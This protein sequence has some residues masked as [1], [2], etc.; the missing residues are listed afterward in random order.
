MTGYNRTFLLLFL[1]IISLSY[2]ADSNWT[3]D[4]D[5]IK[6]NSYKSNLSEE[7]RDNY[8]FWIGLRNSFYF[9]DNLNQLEKLV[10]YFTPEEEKYYTKLYKFS[11]PCLI[12]GG[13]LLVI[14]FVYL[15][16]RFLLRGCR[17]PK[18]VEKS[19]H[20]SAYFF[21]IF[22]VVVG[23]VCMIIGL[24]NASKSK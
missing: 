3:F 17:G 13:A 9:S 22:G 16:K 7:Q 6:I 12:C 4:G 18:I 11:I 24:Y 23:L 1:C 15:I 5:Q 21:L 19:Y 2:Q 14:I 20:H 10:K 8:Y